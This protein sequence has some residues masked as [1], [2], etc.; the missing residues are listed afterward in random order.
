MP[1]ASGHFDSQV[2]AAA[3]SEA[4]FSSA[5][6]FA[7]TSQCAAPGCQMAQKVA[8]ACAHKCCKKHCLEH[9]LPC[10]FTA[11]A[12][13]RWAL[14]MV[15]VP[16]RADLFALNHP[17]PAIPPVPPLNSFTDANPGILDSDPPIAVASRGRTY[18]VAMPN[19]MKQDWDNGMQAH[20]QH[21]QAE[22]K[23]RKNQAMLEHSFTVHAWLHQGQPVTAFTV[24]GAETWPVVDLA[25]QGHLID[26]LGMQDDTAIE[27]YNLT[28]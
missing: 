23:R 8:S 4:P 16:P 6:Q 14:L 2:G 15:P 22:A 5:V 1:M 19:S 25:S 7:S 28:T 10:G 26:A 3:T 12:Q 20:L 21:K 11:H 13:T 27:R 17:P 24:Q 18:S 9:G